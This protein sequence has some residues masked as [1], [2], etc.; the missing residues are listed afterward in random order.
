MPLTVGSKEAEAALA[1]K[2]AKEDLS[3]AQSQPEFMRALH[4]LTEADELRKKLSSGS[5]G[6]PIA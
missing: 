2:R 3:K 1:Q 6:R 5:Q 4:H